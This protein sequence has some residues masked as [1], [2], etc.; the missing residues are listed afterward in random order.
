MKVPKH[1]AIIMDGNGRW[2]KERGLPRIAGHYE[3]VRRAEEVVEACIDLNIKWLTLFA[4]STENWKRPEGE[5]KALMRL[6]EG[7]IRENAKRLTEKGLRVSFVGRRDRLPESLVREME[8]V[9]R[10][11]PKQEKLHVILAVD[12]GGRDEIIRT[13]RKMIETGS[14][15]DES[16]FKLLSDF[17]QIPDPDLLIRTGGERRISN[18]LLWHLAYTELYFTD[19][20]WPDFR[21]EDLLKAI[22]DFSRRERKFGAV[23]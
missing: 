19:T 10:L 18:F 4:F 15:I 8:K 5:V 22:E 17:S 1:L 20:Y 3:G 7:Y 23:L 13:I 14:Q 6:L 21:R 11:R 12:Y 2:A 16:S 9:E